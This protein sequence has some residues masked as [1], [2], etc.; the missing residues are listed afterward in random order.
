MFFHGGKF[1][2]PPWHK[3]YV[4]NFEFPTIQGIMYYL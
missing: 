2:G 4:F 1:Q 3:G